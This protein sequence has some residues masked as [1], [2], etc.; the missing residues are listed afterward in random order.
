V[1]RTFYLLGTESITNLANIYVC[2][3]PMYLPFIWAKI[4]EV[5]TGAN[6]VKQQLGGTD[7]DQSVMN[8]TMG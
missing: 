6:N 7:R 1:G 8:F 5:N 3:G 4:G 2:Q